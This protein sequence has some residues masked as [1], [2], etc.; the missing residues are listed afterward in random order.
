MLH[1][2]MPSRRARGAVAVLALAGLLSLPLPAAAREPV[3]PATLT[4]APNPASN[5]RCGWAGSQVIC[6]SELTFT[7]T[8]APTGIFCGGGALLESS[9]RHTQT[10][11]FYNSNLLLT[12]RI[13]QEWI[14][15]ILYVP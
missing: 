13:T 5:P 2:V 15:G 7:V 3:D 12:K 10:R 14:E 4:P 6:A 9:E 8:D 1:P 11:R